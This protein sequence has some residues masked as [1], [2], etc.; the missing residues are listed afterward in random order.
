MRANADLQ[1]FRRGRFGN[2]CK[3]ASRQAVVPIFVQRQH[4]N[5]YVTGCRIL[6]Q[7]VQHRPAQHVGQENIQR[8]CGRMVFLGQR[9]GFCTA[10]R[11][12]NLEALVPGEIAQHTRIV[13]VI[14]DNQQD[15]IVGL[16]I[17]PVVGNLL[18]RM[19]RDPDVTAPAK[20]TTEIFSPTA[21]ACDVEG[22]TYVCGK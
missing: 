2:K 8:H 3:R 16:Q 17:L 11:H 6:L 4:L 22:P 21:A 5:R 18:D 7:V 9:E 13:R 1:P 10:S 20:R 15:G 12:K 19:L 14:F